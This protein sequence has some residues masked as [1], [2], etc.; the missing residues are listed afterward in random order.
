MK[1]PCC[2]VGFELRLTVLWQVIGFFVAEYWLFRSRDKLLTFHGLRSDSLLFSIVSICG[3][4]TCATLMSI[5]FVKKLSQS[6]SSFPRR[7]SQL[8][9]RAGFF[10]TRSTPATIDQ[11]CGNL[12]TKRPAATAKTADFFAPKPVSWC[13]RPST[14]FLCKESC[15][16]IQQRQFTFRTTLY[17]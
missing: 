2:G 9:C 1:D 17:R 14:K 13:S 3:L 6:R 5:R 7:T 4:A 16:A 10:L 12:A 8:F 15:H 11:S